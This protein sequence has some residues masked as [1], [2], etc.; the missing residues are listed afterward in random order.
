MLEVVIASLILTALVT[1]SSYLVWNTSRTVSSSEVGVQMEI[2]AREFMTQ[3]AKEFHQTSFKFNQVYVVNWDTALTVPLTAFGPGTPTPGTKQNYGGFVSAK[4]PGPDGLVPAGAT[5]FHALRFKIPGKTMD[6]TTQNA[7]YDPKDKVKSQNFDLQTYL[8][9]RSLSVDPPDYTT[10]IQYWWEFDQTNLVNE[11][12]V[13]GNG[14][15][16]FKADG[17]DNNNNGVVDEGVVKKLETTYDVNGNVITRKISTVLRDVQWDAV[18]NR[19]ALVFCIPGA[20]PAG[21]VY[22]GGAEKRLFMSVIMERAD[23]QNPK[24]KDRNF[25]KRVATYIDVRN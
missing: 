13:G 24:K 21:T 25:V 16:G 7:D 19:P 20:D 15:G 12:A 8:K 5:V 6:L 17:L 10:E 3:L 4:Y 14:P 23:P 22:P 11:G 9:A 2:Q 18:N 1:M